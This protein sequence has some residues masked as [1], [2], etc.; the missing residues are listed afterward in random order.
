MRTSRRRAPR[1][2]PFRWRLAA[3]IALTVLVVGAAGWMLWPRPAP[4]SMASHSVEITMAG[5]RPSSVAL[6]AGQP[7]TV[8]LVNPDSPFHT[9]GG[10]IHQFAVPALGVDVLVQ[11]RST[12]EVT[13]PAAAPGTYDFYC[14]NCCGGKESPAMQGKIV[15]G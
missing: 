7:T 13:L 9:D 8:R 3:F 14:D 2:S 6:P 10:G 5:F 15:V 4:A 11:P 1:A 12:M